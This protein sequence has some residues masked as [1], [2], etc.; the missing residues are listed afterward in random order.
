MANS[1]LLDELEKQF[2]DNPRRVFA[3]LANEYRKSGDFERAVEI[4]RAHIPQQPGYI[5]GYIVLGQALYESG[6]L[7]DAWQTL[8]TALGLDPENLIAL[9]YLGDIA[10]E[11]GDPDGARGWYNRLLEVDPQ[12]DEAAGHL[13]AMGALVKETAVQTDA[14]DE[15]SWSDIHPDN[16]ASAIATN[17]DAMPTTDAP[18]IGEPA[19][20]DEAPTEDAVPVASLAA[21]EE[22]ARQKGESAVAST[23]SASESAPDNF[24]EGRM[25]EI[26]EADEEYSSGFVTETMAELYLSQGFK[27]QALHIFR[28]LAREGNGTDSMR[29]RAEEIERQ[30][31]AEKPAREVSPLEPEND[32]EVTGAESDAPDPDPSKARSPV[33][34]REVFAVIAQR[35]PPTSRSADPV[36]ASV[37]DA[38]AP[39]VESTT[40]AEPEP[41]APK[42][43]LFAEAPSESDEAAAAML[44]E[45]F[46]AEAGNVSAIHS[47]DAVTGQP[48][49]AASDELSLDEVF[50]FGRRGGGREGTRPGG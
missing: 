21:D 16:Q 4:C 31:N 15:M 30:I 40:D 49:R 33:T 25:I 9:G 2:A 42:S 23:M 50:G 47:P 19:S 36:G 5:S 18:A 22:E 3:R 11:S 39:V 7:E 17:V 28:Q 12:N 35:R 44:A 48:S 10:R 1:A 45:A 46:P 38:S 32:A 6:Q 34:I 37:D 43:E 29:E 26:D 41:F 14:R 27:E 24:L 20:S 8:E 13:A